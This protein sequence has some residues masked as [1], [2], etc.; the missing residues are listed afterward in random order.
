MIGKF[1]S[2]TYN[3]VKS[4]A[5]EVRLHVSVQ[6]IKAKEVFGLVKPTTVEQLEVLLNYELQK[7]DTA[8]AL[9]ETYK[10]WIYHLSQSEKSE[11]IRYYKTVN[12]SNEKRES[13]SSTI[14]PLTNTNEEH[15]DNTFQVKGKS[16]HTLS[17]SN[18]TSAC[19]S[20]LID[21]HDSYCNSEDEPARRDINPDL[22]DENSAGIETPYKLNDIIDAEPKSHVKLSS[23]ESLPNVRSNTVH[24]RSNTEKSRTNPTGKYDPDHKTNKEQL[25]SYIYDDHY[26]Y[27]FKEFF[28]KSNILEK[29]ISLI[30]E[31][32]EIRLSLVGPIEKDDLENPRTTILTMFS[33]CL[34][35][36]QKLHK[37]ILFIILTTDKLFDNHKELFLE[38]LSVL[39]YDYLDVY[40]MNIRKIISAEV[41][42][43][44]NKI[45]MYDSQFINFSKLSSSDILS[46]STSISSIDLDKEEDSSQHY[47]SR[48]TEKQNVEVP[49]PACSFESL[50]SQLINVQTEDRVA[51]LSSEPNSLGI[52]KKTKSANHT[53]EENTLETE[54]AW[55]NE[56]PRT[57]LY[58]EDCKTE[59][60]T[61]EK[62]IIESNRMQQIKILASGKLIELHKMLQRI[63][64]V[65][66]QNRKKRKVEIKIKLEEL[67]KIME[68]CKKDCEITLH[69]TEDSKVHIENVYVKELDHR[70]NSINQTQEQVDQMKRDIEELLKKKKNIFNEYQ[71]ICN[72][73]NTKNKQL[74]AVMSSLT[75]YKKELNQTEMEYLNKL[76]NTNKAKHMHQERKLYISNLDNISDEILKEYE[77]STYISTEELVSKT[78]KM[79]K[80]LSK[81]ITNHL[82]YLKDKLSLLNT[83]LKFYVQRVNSLLEEQ[84]NEGEGAL[85]TRND[86]CDIQDTLSHSAADTGSNPIGENPNLFTSSNH[87]QQ[88][89]KLKLIKYK[90]CYFKIIEQISKVWVAIQEFYDL[91]KENIED[92]ETDCPPDLVYQQI[93]DLYNYS[94]QFI[95]QNGPIISSIL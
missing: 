3:K 62:E 76:S 19:N 5:D 38:L 80:P 71:I 72:E 68:V 9:I 1:I 58:K 82:I 21:A 23:Q 4:K 36:N 15:K 10:K 48:N 32:R 59:S 79:K 55:E 84:H 26:G 11:A 81:V 43:L 85:G 61:E 22:P 33:H 17:N 89:R 25:D 94:K 50:D 51:Q 44:K 75:N 77:N 52:R 14:P 57:D 20:D 41:L 46:P 87:Q 56:T 34:I 70:T 88:D 27:N 78:M 63:L 91:N 6:A 8:E 95:M 29:S 30:L 18:I 93:N 65:A 37:D 40:L 49:P 54:R 24:E 69:D 86:E 45:Q 64:Q 13:A 31:K 12:R 73:I 60:P 66:T 35:G 83:L 42:S 2:E 47:T 67:K 16:E 53:N 7:I 92:A 28:L 90:K 39:K 74:S